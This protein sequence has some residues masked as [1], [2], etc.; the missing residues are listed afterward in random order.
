MLIVRVVDWVILVDGNPEH[1]SEGLRWK[2]EASR[3]SRE[4]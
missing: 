3:T 4:H 1:V 2:L